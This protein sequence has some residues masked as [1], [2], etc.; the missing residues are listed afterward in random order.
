MKTISVITILLLAASSSFAQT[1]LSGRYELGG[2]VGYFYNSMNGPGD[3][4]TT[5]H[6]ISFRPNIGLFLTP[7]LE[8]TIGPT[9]QLNF[10]K[11]GASSIVIDGFTF[12]STPFEYEI[13][14]IGFTPGIKYHFIPDGAVTPYIA[15][16]GT[17]LWQRQI[18]STF[19]PP[20]IWSKPNIDAPT[21]DAGVRIFLSN[22]WALQIALTYTR[23]LQLQGNT[24]RNGY[25]LALGTGFAIFL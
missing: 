24:D 18:S 8:V 15:V 13:Y 2:S 14:A 20:S 5:T 12:F 7:S 21:V 3:S 10:R 17:L 25:T 16:S 6:D 9:I 4:K 19:N 23:T 22:D 1:D 11:V